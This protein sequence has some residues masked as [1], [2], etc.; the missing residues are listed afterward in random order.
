MFTIIP[1]SDWPA[2]RRAGRSAAATLAE[3]GRRLR[4]GLTTAAI[5]AIVRRDTER[6][7]GTPS[8]LGYHGFPAAVCTSVNHIVCHGMPR[9]DVV[10]Q[11][12]DI[13]N[14]DVTTNLRGWHGDTSRTFFIGAPSPEAR[15]VVET[16]Q[17][18]LEAGIDAAKP[19]GRRGD[20]ERWRDKPVSAAPFD[21]SR[22]HCDWGPTA[23]TRA[24]ADNS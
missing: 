12:G 3:V 14:V 2:M 17:R 24:D 4:P 16:A 1:P 15:H 18:A 10:L 21:R 19:G 5:D 8:Q 22:G 6:R 7:G 9:A 13:I 11:Q 23:S 20:A